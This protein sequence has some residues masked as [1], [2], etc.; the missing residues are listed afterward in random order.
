MRMHNIS[1]ELDEQLN[2]TAG[3]TPATDRIDDL[4]DRLARYHPT[5]TSGHRG[6]LVVMVSLPAEHVA[7]A[8]TTAVAVVEAAAGAATVAVE[9]M[10]SDEFDAR[11]GWTP[12]PEL[13]TVTE[14]AQMLGVTRQA[15]LDRIRRH[16][17]PAEKVGRDYAIPRQ[18][19]DEA[20]VGVTV[21]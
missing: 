13:I 14:A 6:R 7:Q 21:D 5:L 12:L 4:L 16:T 9:A 2:P 20:N 8:V 10:A 18:A 3:A 11:Q 19:L 17:L 1:V 15:V